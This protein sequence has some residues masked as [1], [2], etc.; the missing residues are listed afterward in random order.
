[1]DVPWLQYAIRINGPKWLALTRFDMLSGVKSIPVVVGYKHKGEILPPGKIPT[2]W[3]MSEVEVIKEDWPCFE[4]NI[5]GIN[6][7][8][9]LPESARE[10]LS[11][12]EKMLSVKILL[13]GTGPGREAMVV[14]E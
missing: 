14:R 12:L 5:F 11:R 8:S 3:Q 1:M 13:V 2:S 7:E 4:E 10:F 6:D 9:K